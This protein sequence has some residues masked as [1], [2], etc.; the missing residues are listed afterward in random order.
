MSLL[1]HVQAALESGLV[2]VLV[3][4]TASGKTASA[5]RLGAHFGGALELISADA[6]QVYRGMDIGTAKAPVAERE[7]VRHHLVDICEPTERYTAGR[8][9]REAAAAITGIQARGGIPLVVGGSGL[10]LSALIYGLHDAPP[11]D[12]PP[13]ARPDAP[14]EELLGLLAAIDPAA[15][16]ALDRAPAPRIARALSIVR[17]TGQPLAASRLGARASSGLAFRIFRLV[18][19]RRRIIYPRIDARVLAMFEEGLVEEVVSLRA[20]GVGPDRPSQRAIGYREVHRL[21]DGELFRD[22]AVRQIQAN[23]RRYAKRQET[24]FRTQFRP[25]DVVEVPAED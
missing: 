13:G 1:T 24:W 11:G 12:L 6:F 7:R 3:G 2:P 22:E 14:R 17:A 5:V 21:L 23:S 25:E 9:A 16:S 15:A 4:P 19:D 10:Y 8:F 18:A 20:R